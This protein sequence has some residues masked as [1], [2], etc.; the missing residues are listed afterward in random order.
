MLYEVVSHVLEQSSNFFGQYST[1][2]PREI[3]KMKIILLSNV[4]LD[5]LISVNKNISIGRGVTGTCMCAD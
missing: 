4:S 3:Q 5:K 2:I 1:K